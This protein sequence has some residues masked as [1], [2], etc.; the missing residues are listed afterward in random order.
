M[1]WELLCQRKAEKE[2]AAGETGRL[3]GLQ[4]MGEGIGAKGR[5]W[6]MD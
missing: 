4:G 5:P 6:V 2:K 1:A 3:C